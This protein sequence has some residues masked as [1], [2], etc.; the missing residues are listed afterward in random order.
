LR[1]YDIFVKWA[2][3]YGSNFI[4]TI[5]I[6]DEC[7]SVDALPKAHVVFEHW[8]LDLTQI[9]DR[10]AFFLCAYERLWHHIRQMDLRN[11]LHYE[12]NAIIVKIITARIFTNFKIRDFWK[13]LEFLKMMMMIM[14]I[15]SIY[16]HSSSL[17][18]QSTSCLTSP[19]ASIPL[20]AYEAL[21][22]V[23]HSEGC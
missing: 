19:R 20:Q 17:F 9:N 11:L 1:I 10:L 2:W 22:H 12:A 7:S 5:V 14:M 8:P 18:P 23:F 13:K 4:W 6:L 15:C 16:T 21:P 3:F